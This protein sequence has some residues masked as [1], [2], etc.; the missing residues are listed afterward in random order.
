MAEVVPTTIRGLLLHDAR[1]CE[2]NRI[3]ATSKAGPSYGTPI[4][5][6]TP[7]ARMEVYTGATDAAGGT[8]GSGYAERWLEVSRAGTALPGQGAG[9]IRWA[10]TDGGTQRGWMPPRLATGFSWMCFESATLTYAQP[11]ALALQ[12]GSLLVAYVRE[13]SGASTEIRCK[14]TAP[15]ST[16]G[17]EVLIADDT[18]LEYSL[19]AFDMGPQLVQLPDGRVLCFYLTRRNSVLRMNARESSD[20]GATWRQTVKEAGGIALSVANCAG[21]RVVYHGGYLTCLIQIAANQ[22]YHYVSDSMGASWTG[23]AGDLPLNARGAQLIALPGGGCGMLYVEDG[24]TYLRWTGKS[25]PFSGFNV[26][27]YI[28]LVHSTAGNVAVDIDNDRAYIAACIGQDGSIFAAFRSSG[29]SP[30]CRV[31]LINFRPSVA[32]DS[33]SGYSDDLLW[34]NVEGSWDAEPLSWDDDDERM[35]AL[36]MAPHTGGLRLLSS[37]ET[38]GAG[39]PKSGSIGMITLG[40]WSS[41]TVEVVTFG[42]Y[43]DATPYGIC[44]VP[45]IAPQSVAGW[46]RTGASVGSLVST[47][48]QQSFAGAATDYYSVTGGD[49]GYLFALFTHTQNSGGSR[50]ADDSFV[51]ALC[52]DGATTEHNVK[53][54]FEATSARLVDMNNAGATLGSDLTG[55]TAA[56]AYDWQVYM[57]LDTVYV[58][59]KLTTATAWTLWQSVV[60]TSA[61]V[62]ASSLFEWG[63]NSTNNS[64]ATWGFVGVS[65]YADP[66]SISHSVVVGTGGR[67]LGVEPVYVSAGLSVRAARA[68][69]MGGDTWDVPLAHVYGADALDPVISPSPRRGWRSTGTTEQTIV[70]DTGVGTTTLLSPAIG[71]HVSRPLARTVYLEGSPDNAAW[72]TLVTLDC[73]AGMSG[74]TFS[75]S[76][77]ILTRSGGTTGPDFCGLDELVGGWAIIA[78]AGVTYVREILSN[79]DGVWAAT[80]KPLKIRVDG[81]PSLPTS[82]TLAIIRPAAT[83]IAWS[84]T[85]LYRYYR[86]RVAALTQDAASP[87]Y[88]AL[89]AVA[90]GALIPFGQQYSL[91][92]TLATQHAQ[93]VTTLQGG[94][95]SVRTLGP[96]RRAV[97]FA[98]VEGIDTT[99]VYRDFTLSA[100]PD[101]VAAVTT[102]AGLAT[103]RATDQMEGILSR[104]SG[105]AVPVVYL[106]DLTYAGGGT[107]V[108]QRDQQ[109]YGR[110][111]TD[112]L[113]R[114]AAMGMESQDEI[115]TIG[116]V[117]I[118][119]EV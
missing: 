88:L 47:G 50:T 59:Y 89:G 57:N 96:P 26:D 81:A 119:E 17:S 24:H 112:T 25:A 32:A 87:G 71:L 11:H 83:G 111:L 104:Q 10:E 105:A 84:I 114:V 73:A 27:T 69:V 116:T 80:G 78:D 95:R 113:T 2:A 35:I 40:G 46:T 82:G 55:L 85:T 90:I 1:I 51:H 20:N 91:G 23:I 98:W 29:A 41:T 48:F 76:G 42:Q 45:F 19:A 39:S 62:A 9:Q 16:T 92:R 103:R 36:T 70:W 56:T 22:A 64:T 21:L 4:P 34:S 75:R 33:A 3:S 65:H 31:K 52:T 66:T 15:E 63:T 58:W 6:A 28:R 7:R 118:E 12:D 53:I 38:G 60:P 44:Y 43:D 109:L 30:G 54:R 102:G 117:R 97:E 13:A 106:P 110:V 67:P 5:E 37:Y 18:F 94:A 93:E 100:T 8:A 99:Q 86:V 74:L 77:N 61:S 72:T 14:R 101:Y 115:H 68:P 107:A 49:T 108:A 79:E